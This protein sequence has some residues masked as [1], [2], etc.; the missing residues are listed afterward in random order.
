MP[1][2]TA[3]LLTVQMNLDR[4]LAVIGI[5]SGTVIGIVGIILAIYYARKAEKK[6]VPTFVVSPKEVRLA[7]DLLY[8]V[9]GCAVI[10]NGAPIGKTGL[11]EILVYF[12]N[13]GNLPIL[14]EDILTQFQIELPHHC[15]KRA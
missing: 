9:K 14:K 2:M 13:S 6:R 10:Q 15:T 12:F 5:A 11:T 7:S 3:S 8:T 1:R 4:W